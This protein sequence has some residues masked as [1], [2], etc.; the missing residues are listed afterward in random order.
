WAG[1]DREGAEQGGSEIAS[2][3]AEKVAIDVGF[4]LGR[5]PKGMAHRRGL[6]HDD[7]R[8]DQRERHELPYVAKGRQGKARHALR[9]ASDN[10][11][12]AAFEAEWHHGESRQHDTDESAGYPRADPLRQQHENEDSEADRGRGLAKEIAPALCGAKKGRHLRNNDMDRNAC[13][14]AGY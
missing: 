12:A 3:D 4:P 10:G 11:D 6:Y 5:I 1:I 8:N 13:Q 9:Q 2:T 7:E 14:E